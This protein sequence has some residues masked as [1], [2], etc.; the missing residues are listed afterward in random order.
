MR[1]ASR[2]RLVRIL[3][4]V[5]TLTARSTRHSDPAPD[6]GCP[7]QRGWSTGIRQVAAEVDRLRVRIPVRDRLWIEPVHDRVLVE[8]RSR[9]SDFSPPLISA[10]RFQP[11]DSP[12]FR[13]LLHTTCFLAARFPSDAH[14]VHPVHPVYLS[15]AA[16]LASK[17]CHTPHSCCR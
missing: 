17:Q 9:H 6:P 7:A 13:F 15:A 10:L 5:V 14:P 2:V 4:P 8:C 3:L 16:L 1:R 11:A 12:R